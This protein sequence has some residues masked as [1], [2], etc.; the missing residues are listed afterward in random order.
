MG[1]STR[2]TQKDRQDFHQE[3]QHR[4][5]LESDTYRRVLRKR[6]VLSSPPHLYHPPGQSQTEQISP[7]PPIGQK[8]LRPGAAG[9]ALEHIFWFWFEAGRVLL[10]RKDYKKGGGRMKALEKLTHPSDKFTKDL[11]FPPLLNEN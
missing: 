2:K 9:R 5:P 11:H 6:R 3:P 7:G 1:V 8:L 10:Q 4:Q